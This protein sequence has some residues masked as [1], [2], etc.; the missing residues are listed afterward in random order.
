MFVMLNLSRILDNNMSSIAEKI[1][2]ADWKGE[3]HVP[4]I[5]CIDKAGSDDWIDVLVTV[6]KEI[7]HPNTVEHHIRWIRVYYVPDD[8]NFAVDVGNYEFN[9]HGEGA[10][11]VYTHSKTKFSFKA[12]KSGTLN[13]VSYCNI[14]GLWESSKSIKI[15]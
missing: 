13:V 6:G 7:P 15:D 8:S 12:S 10:N 4:V 9:T 11:P 14:H 3:K 2:T 1:K 5:D